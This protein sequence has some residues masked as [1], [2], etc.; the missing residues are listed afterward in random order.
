[1]QA[2]IKI[3]SGSAFRQKKYTNPA[4]ACTTGCNTPRRKAN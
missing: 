4:I 3:A 2:M 1:M